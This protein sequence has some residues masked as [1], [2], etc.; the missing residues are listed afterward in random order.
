[1]YRIVVFMA[2]MLLSSCARLDHVHIGDID[3]SEGQLTKFSVKVSET[4][5]EASEFAGIGSAVTKGKTSDDFE[6]VRIAL[7]VSNMGPRPGNPG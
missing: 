1:M 6:I 5:V 3:Q 7:A 2:I 4:G